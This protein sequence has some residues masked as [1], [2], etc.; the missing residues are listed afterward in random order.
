MVTHIEGK[1]RLRDYESRVLR[2]IFEPK[3]DLVIGEWRKLHSDELNELYFSSNIIRVIKWRIMGWVG[4]LARM[5][6]GGEHT[7]IWRGNLR[8][9]DH[10]ED[11]GLDG[12]TVLRTIFRKW[13]VWAWTG[14]IR[15]R[16]GRGGGHL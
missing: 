11:S 16:I 1:R 5:G 13:D 4:N 14:S 3:R 10:L 15:L 12:R 2:R 8:E 7:G 9:R 6:R